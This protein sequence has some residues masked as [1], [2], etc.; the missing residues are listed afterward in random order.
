[1]DALGLVVETV[2]TGVVKGVIDGCWESGRVVK[3]GEL[4]DLMLFLL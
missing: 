1:M 4:V 3:Q 2:K